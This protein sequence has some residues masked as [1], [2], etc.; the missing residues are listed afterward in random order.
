M[1]RSE[2]INMVQG[3]SEDDLAQIFGHLVDRLYDEDLEE[4]AARS[5]VEINADAA[6]EIRMHLE[7]KI[8][9]N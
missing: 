3:W 6:E 8:P 4:D 7:N 2:I 9:E 5:A 1:Q